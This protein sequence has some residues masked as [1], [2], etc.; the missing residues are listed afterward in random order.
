MFA[1]HL[2]KLSEDFAISSLS[3]ILSACTKLVAWWQSTVLVMVDR[4]LGVYC[5]EDGSG[6]NRR[7]IAQQSH[8]WQ[9][10]IA[11]RECLLL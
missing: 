10:N 6:G 5:T 4:Q 2:Q 7:A 9:V 3:F 8:K 1:T 11:C